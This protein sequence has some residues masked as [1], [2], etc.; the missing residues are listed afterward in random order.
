MKYLFVITFILVYSFFGLE[1]GYTDKSGI[2]SHFTYMFQH[3]NI[4]HLLLNSFSFIVVWIALQKHV[5]HLY[6]LPMFLI[7]FVASFLPYASFA[8]PT[9]G[10]SGVVYAMMGIL[11]L[12]LR[13]KN[14]A[15]FLLSV[16]I[17]LIISYFVPN[18]NFFIHLYCF[19]GGVVYGMFD[20]MTNTIH[21][22]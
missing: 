13:K 22:D 21:Y 4:I 10:V 8:T 5:K 17:A 6:I 2:L 12:Y 18:S 1:L 14:L 9:V 7:A 16:L 11:A 20:K 3:I 15:I 19:L